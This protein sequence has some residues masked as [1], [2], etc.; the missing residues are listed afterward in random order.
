MHPRFI[1]GA[2]TGANDC[3]R[4]TSLVRCCVSASACEAGT[5]RIAGRWRFDLPRGARVS[6]HDRNFPCSS[7]SLSNGVND[8]QQG[9]C[10]RE[11]AK[12]HPGGHNRRGCEPVPAGRFSTRGWKNEDSVEIPEGRA[13]GEATS[14][15][16]CLEDA[17][18]DPQASPGRR[19]CSRLIIVQGNA[20]RPPLWDELGTVDTDVSRP[21]RLSRVSSISARR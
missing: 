21:R 15:M 16:G 19:A 10:T 13:R 1:Q 3:P 11:L 14:D 20:I 2:S 4:T 8:Y 6:D 9:H 7:D 12:K 5:A 18:R 17:G